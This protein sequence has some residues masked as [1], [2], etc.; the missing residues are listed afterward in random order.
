M[1]QQIAA[2]KDKGWLH[3]GVVNA[4]IVV[5]LELI[6][7]CQNCKSV[8]IIACLIGVLTHSHRISLLLLLAAA[9]VIP[10]KL[11]S[12]QICEYLLPSDLGTRSKL[13]FLLPDWLSITQ[14]SADYI[15][16]PCKLSKAWYSAECQFIVCTVLNTTLSGYTYQMQQP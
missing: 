12:G 4:L 10:L 16:L 9:W 14:M 11:G 1:V 13:K 7:F 2:I 15:A 8:C 5:C 3:H 6:P